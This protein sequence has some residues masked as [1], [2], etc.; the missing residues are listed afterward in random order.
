MLRHKGS[1][2]ESS[3]LFKA[4]VADIKKATNNSI[5]DSEIVNCIKASS[6][7]AQSAFEP[8]DLPKIENSKKTHS[9]VKK[10]KSLI[11]INRRKVVDTI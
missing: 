10:S 11:S 7:G 9:V 1:L 8:R 6:M 4:L 2:N 3:S 5:T